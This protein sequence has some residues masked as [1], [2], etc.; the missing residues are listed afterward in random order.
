[1][2]DLAIA[3]DSAKFGTPEAKIGLY[4]MMIL[5]YMLRLIPRRRLVEMCMTAEPFGAA[6]ALEH[7]LLNRVV[8]ADQLDAALDK[9]LGTLL[10]NSPSALLLGKKAFR[11]MQDMTLDECFEYAQLMIARMSQTADA[12]EGMAAFVEKRPPNWPG[13]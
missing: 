4:P 9:L 12:R 6:E 5:S 2:C 3:V 10:A 13:V 8:P 1:M 11:A 7:G